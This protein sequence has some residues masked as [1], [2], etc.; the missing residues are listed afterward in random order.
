MNNNL[1]C[2]FSNE[3]EFQEEIK[4]CCENN[5]NTFD[6]RRKNRE[7]ELSKKDPKDLEEA[8][9]IFFRMIKDR[10]GIQ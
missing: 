7:E 6:E 5:R 9:N 1:T 4:K 3:K 10:K 8:H 2:K